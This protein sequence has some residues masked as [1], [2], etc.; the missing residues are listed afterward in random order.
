MM[1]LSEKYRPKDW[2]EVVSQKSVISALKEILAKCQKP[3]GWFDSNE[4]TE[5]C[6][7]PSM[8]F[9]GPPGT[10]KTTLARIFAKKHGSSVEEFNASDERGLEVIRERIKPLSKVVVAVLFYLNEADGITKDAQAALRPIMENSKN[11]VFILDV[12]DESKI[13]DAIKSRCTVFRFEPLSPKEVTQRLSEICEGEGIQLTADEEEKAAFAQI[14]KNAN[15]DMRKAINELEKIITADRKL[16]A[17]NILEN[18]EPE[19][20]FSKTDTGETKQ[21]PIEGWQVLQTKEGEFYVTDVEIK[22]H[23]SVA[24]GRPYSYGRIQLTLDESWVGL[25]AKVT[26][27]KPKVEEL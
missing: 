10:G 16:N 26:V 15:G 9:I 17:A 12:N 22:R 14:C 27:M 18:A 25:K 5:R 24:Q 11:A 21:K 3:R 23:M 13:I 6:K 2:D 20:S 8:L 4:P 19:G 7:P 1:N